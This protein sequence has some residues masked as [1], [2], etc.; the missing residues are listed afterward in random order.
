GF[1]AF[2]A[3]QKVGRAG[4]VLGV[5]MTDDMLALARK[6]AAELGATNVEFRKGNTDALPLE[7]DSVD[8]VISNCVINLST[9]KPAVFREISRVLKPGGRFAVSD[10]VLLR[11]LPEAVAK[12]INAYVGCIAGASLLGDYI[13]MAIEAGLNE[14]SIPQITASDKLAAAYGLDVSR[15]GSGCCGS[16]VLA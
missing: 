9:D 15:I 8:L 14:L 6:N 5:D 12:D 11:P 10:L 7:A 2:L 16:N 4:R 13:R 3:W 1:D